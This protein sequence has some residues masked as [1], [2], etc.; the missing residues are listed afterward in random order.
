[1][2]APSRHSDGLTWASDGSMLPASAGILDDK[3][4]TGAA[5][6]GKSL[7]LKILGCNVSILHGEQ[8][9]LII[10]L[11]LAGDLGQNDLVMILTDHLN[12]VRLIND[13]QTNVSQSSRLCYMNGRSYYR[14]ILSLISRSRATVSYT[15]GHSDES[16]VE[17]RLN[18]EADLLA[19]SS[20]KIYKELLYAPIPSFFMNDFTIH[21]EADGWIESNVMH[22]IDALLARKTA[23]AL[24]IGHDLRMSTWAHDPGP[25]PDFPYIKAVSAHSAAIQL[26]ARSGQLAMADV[27][28]RRGKK[29][30]DL[31]CLGCDATGDMHHIFVYCI[32]LPKFGPEPR[33][34]P[35]PSGLNTKFGSSSGSG[36]GSRKFLEN[37]FGLNRTSEPLATGEHTF[38][39]FSTIFLQFFSSKL[40]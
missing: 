37:R 20:Q 8:I 2:L 11:V 32:A 39:L 27:L 7:A 21:S 34:E 38:P 4:V 33:F 35:E 26:Y 13:S 9:G 25:P 16:T 3:S 12:S 18:E 1:M 17:A 10:A 36:S 31:C 40:L 22:F 29:D 15:A 23:K 19:T 30:S 14:W 5:I 6:R 24:G 28:Y